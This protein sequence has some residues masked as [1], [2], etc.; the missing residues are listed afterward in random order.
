M[1]D[2]ETFDQ[3]KKSCKSVRSDRRV[4]FTSQFNHT[5]SFGCDYYVYV[6]MDTFETF[7]PFTKK[8]EGRKYK[9]FH[10]SVSADDAKLKAFNYIK[11]FN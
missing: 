1:V 8:H 6:C 7:N 3:F 5:R 9:S 10:S 11:A 2:N 4:Q